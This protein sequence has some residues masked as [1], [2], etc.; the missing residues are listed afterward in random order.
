MNSPK[1]LL[2]LI[3]GTAFA[4][5]AHYSRFT[6]TNSRAERTDAV[7]GFVKRL[8]QIVR[9]RKPDYLA[10]VFDAKGKTFRDDMYPKYKANRKP[11]P[12]ELVFQ[13]PI[14]EQLVTDMGIKSISI[15]GVEADDVIGTL[16]VAADRNGWNTVIAS[17]DKDLAQLVNDSITL[18]DEHQELDFGPQQ[19]FDKFGVLP[20]QIVDFF[21]L[22]GDS[23]DNIPG[24]RLVGK[25]T[26]AKWLSNFGSLEELLRNA[27]DIKGKA[28]ENLRNSLDEIKMWHTLV[29][30]KLDVDVGFGLEDLQMSAP[31]K[32]ALKKIYTRLEFNSF[33]NE[34]DQSDEQTKDLA[35]KYHTVNTEKS[36]SNLIKRMSRAKR[37]AV[38]TEDYWLRHVCRHT[39]GNFD[40]YRSKGRLLYS[41]RSQ[42]PER[43]STIGH[44]FSTK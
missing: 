7:Y 36:F 22:V 24:V 4:Y 11:M 35:P 20:N 41:T 3:D 26:A 2:Y 8:N 29:T 39:R 6:L 30:L 10:V 12:D 40:Q 13:H 38:D 16:A 33:L 14:I 17:N 42:L 34:L 25:K 37:F 31:N 32:N 21:S 44:R 15:P 19:V 23:V 43:Y 9:L 28:G 1:K 5:R 27:S 18:R